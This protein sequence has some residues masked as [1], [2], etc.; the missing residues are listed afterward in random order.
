MSK[1]VLVTG[2]SGNLG[3]G[4]VEALHQQGH[5]ILATLGS[6]RDLGA[7]GHLPQV[8]SQILNVLDANGVNQFLEEQTAAA[9]IQAAVLLVGGFATGDIHH[10][11]AA[12]LDKMYQL[13][14]MS[15]FNVVKPLLAHF[16]KHGGGQF[17]L[18]GT[19]PALVAEE[20]KKMFAYALSKSLIFK[21][22][23]LINAQ[24][25]DDHITATVIVP[26]TIDTP[27]N[28]H[29]MPH[30]DPSKWISPDD[31]GKTVA[32]V[33]SETGQTLREPV[34]KLYNKS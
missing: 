17:V 27:P 25:K 3:K 18:V 32:F 10:T 28:R 22:A 33:L 14:F 11:D 15:A 13:N 6:D 16:E 29:A 30:A 7:F 31:I 24:G 19:R 5:S 34:I 1:L 2:A 26:S 21:M 12:A 20:G 8:K 23:E 4:I 9:P